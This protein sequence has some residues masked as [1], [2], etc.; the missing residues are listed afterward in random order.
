MNGK[1]SISIKET[2]D[3]L[4]E[5][6]ERVAIG[7]KTFVITKFGK[8]KAQISPLEDKIKERKRRRGLEASFGMW[9][10]RK[11]IKDSARWVADLRKKASSRYGKIFS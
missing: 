5:I 8:P 9:K 2:R 1:Q 11:D 6:I 10:D 4:S 7:K 3:N